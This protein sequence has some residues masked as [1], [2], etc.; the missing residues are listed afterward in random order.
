MATW[1]S[2]FPVKTRIDCGADWAD[3]ELSWEYNTT[4][5]ILVVREEIGEYFDYGGAVPK[6]ENINRMGKEDALALLELLI[7]WAE[8]YEGDGTVER[9]LKKRFGDEVVSD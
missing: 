3:Y 8:C 1:K 2:R 6:R 7:D 5:D 9:L 4:S